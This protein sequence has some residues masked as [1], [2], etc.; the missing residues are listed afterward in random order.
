M[1]YVDYQNTHNHIQ[2]ERLYKDVSQYPNLDHNSNK[3]HTHYNLDKI[4]NS[5]TSWI[6]DDIEE[7]LIF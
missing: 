6:C 1:I 3:Q 7:L 4:L 5:N 2:K